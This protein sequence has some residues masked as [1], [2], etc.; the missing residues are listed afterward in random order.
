MQEKAQH[1]ASLRH[2][3]WSTVTSNVSPCY[4]VIHLFKSF[5]SI[6]LSFISLRGRSIGH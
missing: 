4:T 2:E 1:L 5:E 6:G 3:E